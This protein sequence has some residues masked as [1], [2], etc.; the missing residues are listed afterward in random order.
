MLA[1]EAV[2]R[3]SMDNVGLGGDCEVDHGDGRRFEGAGESVRC[4][5]SDGV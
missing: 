2:R 4:G 5:R 1:E 3:Q